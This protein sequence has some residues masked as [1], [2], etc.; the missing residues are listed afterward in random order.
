[1]CWRTLN[2]S[3][4]WCSQWC[5]FCNVQIVLIN[6]HKKPMCA[7]SKSIKFEG[8]YLWTNFTKTIAKPVVWV[9]KFV[10]PHIVHIIGCLCNY[11]PIELSLLYPLVGYRSWGITFPS[12]T[13]QIPPKMVKV[14]SYYGGGNHHIYGYRPRGSRMF[15]PLAPRCR[16]LFAIPARAVRHSLFE[17]WT[18]GWDVW[19]DK[20]MENG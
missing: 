9:V 2:M 16:S 6:V 13:L 5:F 17:A 20:G 12:Q 7:L 14:Q 11:I 1:M 4:S 3:N 8:I 10:Y 19:R 18:C 15:G